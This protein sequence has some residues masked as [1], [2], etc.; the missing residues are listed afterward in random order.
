MFGHGEKQ[1]SMYVEW[2]REFDRLRF[3]LE[4]LHSALQYLSSDP[5]I[6]RA[7]HFTLIKMHVGHLRNR[8]HNNLTFRP[9]AIASTVHHVGRGSTS[10]AECFRKGLIALPKSTSEDPAAAA[11]RCDYALC[12]SPPEWRI[13]W[14]GRGLR[15]MCEKHTMQLKRTQTAQAAI[16]ATHIETGR[17]IVLAR[18]AGDNPQGNYDQVA[19]LQPAELPS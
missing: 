1:A 8:K 4:E 2:K 19:E 11:V 16:I 14:P 3:T 13:N 9:D 18:P 5:E 7:S 6:V 10:F 15:Q 17:Q 12:L